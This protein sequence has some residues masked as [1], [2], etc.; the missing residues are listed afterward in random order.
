MIRILCWLLQG[1]AGQ[2]ADG[3]VTRA[4]TAIEH[5][6]N[7][8]PSV[9]SGGDTGII[10]T[11]IDKLDAGK[12]VVGSMGAGGRGGNSMGGSALHHPARAVRDSAQVGGF[13]WYTS[14][15]TVA[16]VHVVAVGH[17]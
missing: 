16:R 12:V 9:I 1:T 3:Q 6:D 17:P 2:G 5:D 14:M 13:V 7:G 11:G 15:L 8:G 10:N 4:G